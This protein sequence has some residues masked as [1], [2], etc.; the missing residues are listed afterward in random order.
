MIEDIYMIPAETPMI[1]EKLLSRDW[2]IHNYNF[3]DN[4]ELY[5][6]AN[7]LHNKL[8]EGIKYYIILDT[9]IYQ[10]I[11][12]SHKKRP[13]KT[14][15]DIIA[16]LAF[17]QF[18]GIEIEPNLAVYEK[19]NYNRE[20]ASETIDDLILFYRINNSDNQSLLDYA[21][22]KTD[23]YILG[24][25]LDLDKQDLKAQ[26]TKYDRLTEWDSMY[27]IMLAIISISR[28]R[29]KPKEK[30]IKFKKW[31]LKEFRQS[32]IG[33]VYA[34]IFFSQKPLKRMMKFKFEDLSQSRKQQIFNMT[35]DLYIM[36]SFFRKW[37]AKDHTTEYLYASD[38]KAFRGLLRLAIEIQLKNNLEPLKSK[39]STKDY[40]NIM[41]ADKLEVTKNER[42]F[43]SNQWTFE[44]RAK[45]IKQYENELLT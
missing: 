10:F 2:L 16:L 18:C 19:I 4:S 45:M 27:L 39:V 36:N 17:C 13:S 6:P 14:R 11:L 37:T 40:D 25:H 31:M 1:I 23:S 32:L 44:Y 33:F 7:F 35:W 3:Q 43:K 12:N 5:Q 29:I 26:L 21:L 42:I 28:K 30:L 38:D 24:S 34:A 20:K 9:N 8:V 15:R 41:V 22:G